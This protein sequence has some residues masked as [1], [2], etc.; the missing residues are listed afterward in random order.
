ML[1]DPISSYNSNIDFL[2]KTVSKN[3]DELN[4]LRNIDKIKKIKTYEDINAEVERLLYRERIIFAVSALIA[5]SVGIT[6]MKLI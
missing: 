2:D 3:K 4:K 5:I 6:T 1:M